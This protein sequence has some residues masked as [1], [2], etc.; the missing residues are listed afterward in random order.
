[1][2]ALI[3]IAQYIVKKILLFDLILAAIAALSFLFTRGFSFTAYSE[4]L[5]WFSVAVFFVGGTV[6]MANLFS[7][8]TAWSF[9]F[10]RNIRTPEKAK[11][12]MDDV[13]AARK[14]AERRLDVGIQI[15]LIGLGC[16][17]LSALVQTLL[18]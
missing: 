4:R 16:L 3:R 10:P 13:P 15:W 11:Q 6:V 5:L 9:S 8:G 14:L 1:M 18:G 12:F 17:G 7:G 2:A